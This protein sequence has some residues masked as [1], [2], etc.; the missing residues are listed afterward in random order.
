MTSPTDA[1][2]V[3]AFLT[4]PAARPIFE[5]QGFTVLR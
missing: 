5:K 2:R 3:L 1:A 4:L